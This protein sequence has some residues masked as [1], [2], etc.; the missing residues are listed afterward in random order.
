MPIYDVTAIALDRRTGARVTA[1]RVERIDTEDNE[2][3]AG[4]ANELDVHEMYE[5]FW[6]GLVRV[7]TV[8]R[9]V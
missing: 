1:P 4:C 3:F 5:Q 6:N 7:L 8:Q 9:V 2:L